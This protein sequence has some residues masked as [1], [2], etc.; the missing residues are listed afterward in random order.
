MNGKRSSRNCADAGCTSACMPSVAAATSARPSSTRAVH[1][2]RRILMGLK[3]HEPA[4]PGHRSSARKTWRLD[5]R[6]ARPQAFQ[7]RHGGETV[8][9]K[10]AA[11]L[12]IA[13]R[14]TGLQ[15]EPPARLAHV[16]TVACEM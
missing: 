13:H 6:L 7:N 4:A 10:A 16:E 11:R 8:R 2:V 14:R 15:S 3:Y 12:K 5:G 9:H 1:R